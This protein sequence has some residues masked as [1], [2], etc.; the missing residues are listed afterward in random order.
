MARKPVAVL[1]AALS[2][3]L[4][5]GLAPASALVVATGD[6]AATDPGPPAAGRVPGAEQDYLD[7]IDRPDFAAVGQ[8]Q[9]DKPIPDRV[10]AWMCL[11]LPP[12]EPAGGTQELLSYCNIEGCWDVVDSTHATW[13]GSGYYGYGDQQLGKVHLD[14]KVTLNGYQTISYPV[15]FESTRGVRNLYVEG[16]RLY[17]SAT[18][19]GGNS[20]LGGDTWAHVGPYTVSANT[21]KT[22][23]YPGYKSYEKTASRISIVHQWTWMD[24][25]SSYPGKWWLWTKSNVAYWKDVGY[26][27]LVDDD[28][29][30]TNPSDA[31]YTP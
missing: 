28:N 21:K 26:R 15:R 5:L 11:G 10:G 7:A 6:G 19:P 12:A 8:A 14:F 20:V 17:L 4:A 30:P 1:V 2:F 29:R 27:F 22:W 3:V 16:E 25:S 13:Y 31:G 9:C 23:P 18:Y 24:P